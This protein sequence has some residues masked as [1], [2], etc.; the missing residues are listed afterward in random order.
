MNIASESRDPSDRGDHPSG[1]VDP[2]DPRD[3]RGL[4]SDAPLL[5]AWLQFT[6]QAEAGLL[7]PMA[8][9]GHKQRQDL[10]GAV[11]A[12]DAPL[13]GGLDA[14]KR[15]DVMRADAEARAAALWGADWC[16][17]SVAGS[18]HGNQ[19]LALA[20]GS[21][22]REIIVTRILHRSILLG[23]VLAGL[24]PVWVRP[25]MDA[26]SGLPAAVSV[27]TVRAALAAHPDACAVFLGDPSYVGT[28][29]DLA[30]HA[31]AA[32]EAGVPLLV[33]AAWAAHLGFHPDLP[34]H[35]LAAG[36]DAMVTSAHKALPAYSQAAIVLAR[37]GLLDAAR[38][39]RA[40]EATHTTSPA[41]SI[42]ASIDAARVLLA[43]DGKDL[44]A[45]LLRGVAAARQRIAQV[46]GAAV[47]AGPGVEPT[48]LVVLLAG[49]GA[50]GYAV[51]ADL[52]AANMPVESA[53][54]DTVIPIPT[55]ADDEDQIAAFTDVLIASIERHR[56]P[57]R[58]P[59]I[60]ASWTVV[61]ETVL[62]P[63]E[64][65]FAPN[66][67]VAADAAIGRISAELIAP[68]PPGVPVLAPGEL[69]SA[70]AI[71][72]LRE[73]KADGGRIAYAADPSLATFQVIVR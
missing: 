25:E 73:V 46:P 50:N 40:F 6:A 29:G 49:T 58:R 72:S 12:G 71:A 21:D 13:Y 34:A 48:K 20:V 28:T 26:T 38:L 24:R 62:S 53:D 27:R 33:D 65:F 60:A 7:S 41:G 15:A 57:P 39:D 1:A 52:I 30:G 9:P 44:C 42:M 67:T 66:E 10:T 2:S 64:A 54:R 35:A 3:P 43:R 5:D 18:T 16:R 22:G 37:T 45:R 4:R 63:R 19:A 31:A 56:G 32:H 55:L 69:I 14:I 47:L 11:V 8:V 68:Y 36:A 51:E 17:F 23:L 70:D 59:S 61:P